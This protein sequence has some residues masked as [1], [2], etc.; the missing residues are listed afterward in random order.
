M[1]ANP[2]VISNSLGGSEHGGL[3]TA[4]LEC[5]MWVQSC[6]RSLEQGKE[7]EPERVI[8]EAA[9]S[10]RVSRSEWSTGPCGKLKA[11][12]SRAY[13][14]QETLSQPCFCTVELKKIFL[15]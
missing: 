1:S 11:S 10:L 8:G 12:G 9:E 5:S 4:G 3:M 13:L 2:T 7:Q 14:E 6:K 15:E